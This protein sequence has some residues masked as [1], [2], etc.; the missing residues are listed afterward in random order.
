[1]SPS[2]QQEQKQPA[3][4]RALEAAHTSDRK[5]EPSMNAAEGT[6]RKVYKFVTN[7]HAGSAYPAHIKGPRKLVGLFLFLPAN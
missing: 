6:S 4:H 3:F 5:E 7:V 1:M 2:D